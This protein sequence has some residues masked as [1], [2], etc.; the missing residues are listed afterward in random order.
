MKATGG[1]ENVLPQAIHELKV[2]P[3]NGCLVLFQE[4]KIV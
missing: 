2:T 3:G 1:I 4:K